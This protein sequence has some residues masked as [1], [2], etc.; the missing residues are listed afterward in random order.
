MSGLFVFLQELCILYSNKN[1]SRSYRKRIKQFLSQ[2]SK[3][4]GTKHGRNENMFNFQRLYC[5]IVGR[6][7]VALYRLY[8]FDWL[9]TCSCC[10]HTFLT[11]RMFLN[12]IRCNEIN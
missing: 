5:L 6:Q 12:C 4:A 8:M 7:R 1:A 10:V 2:F 3:T 9:S 11:P